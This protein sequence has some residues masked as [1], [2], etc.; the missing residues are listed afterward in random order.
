MI[1]HLF[2]T[3]TA[4]RGYLMMALSQQLHV[5]ISHPVA[6]CID[7]NLLVNY[8]P[9]ALKINQSVHF[10]FGIIYSQAMVKY[11]FAHH[12]LANT[13]ILFILPC[14]LMACRIFVDG[15]L[16]VAWFLFTSMAIINARWWKLH[17]VI[18]SFVKHSTSHHIHLILSLRLP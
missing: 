16:M 1:E 13:L 7:K 5:P 17:L 6:L 18:F 3:M 10:G 12:H 14:P 11:S 15:I 9:T 8:S 2:L 4:C